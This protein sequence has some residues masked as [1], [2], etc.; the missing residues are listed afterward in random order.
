MKRLF[1]IFLFVPCFLNL[2][3]Q[4]T[5]QSLA[6]QFA[7]PKDEYK[8][9]VW[10]HWLGSNFSKEGI[11][12]DLEAM[13]KAGINGVVIFN[14][15]SWLDTA[16]NL[17]PRQT[18]R[19]EE[20]WDAFRHTLS[21]ARRLKITVGLHNSPGWST[22]G[23]P[24]IDPVKDGMKAVRVIKNSE[25]KTDLEFFPTYQL[26]HPTPEDV[27]KTAFEADK[28]SPE[29][30][31]KHWKNVLQPLTE[32]FGEFI[33]TTFTNIWIDSYEAWGQNLTPDFRKEFI[34]MKGYDPA[35]QLIAA[36]ERGDSILNYAT[37][38]LEDEKE[39][40]SEQTKIFL[41]DY[42]DVVNRLFLNCFQ[43][44]KEMVNDAGFQLYWEPYGSI[45]DAPF[46][47]EE[48][49][50]IADVPAT[51]FWVHSREIAGEERFAPAA[52]R[53]GKRI[54]AAEAFTG[55][56]ATCTFNE[57]PA[58]LKRPADM[59]FNYGVNQLFLHSWAHNPLSDAFQPG[60]SFAHYGTHFG[61][62]QTWTEE[63]RAFFTYLARCQMML[64]QGS[65]I[66][67]NDSVL[68]RSTPEAEIFFVRNTRKQKMQHIIDAQNCRYCQIWDPYSGK[69]YLPNEYDKNGNVKLSLE[70]DESIFVIFPAYKTHYDTAEPVNSTF[71][72]KEQKILDKWRVT[73]IPKTGEK[74]FSTTFYK[75]T[76]WSK[77]K[78][79]RIKYFSG[80]AVYE[81]TFVIANENRNPLVI[82]DLGE[83][84]D[85][86]TVEINDE[87]VAVLWHPPFTVDITDFVKRGTNS[88]KIKVTNTWQNRLIGD[89]QFPADYERI[90][91]ENNGLPAAK[92][93]PEWV[94][95]PSVGESKGV[96]RPSKERKTFVPWTYFD[97]N[98]ELAPA[99]LLGKVKLIIQT[100]E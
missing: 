29:A 94:K 10:W 79:S 14:A 35:P 15:P 42:H 67:R 80:S 72:Q 64:Q 21:E 68:H 34:A 8:P 2:F 26:T 55:M 11:T 37:N 66:E 61:R 38:G 32:R 18:F 69:I 36:Y 30:T 58:L 46:R 6:E 63:S 33:G 92:G 27:E 65:F 45:I 12:A 100:P 87:E 25:G 93:L 62:N 98:S 73:F 77:N 4:E 17:A 28:M 51:E 31:R 43:I 7:S 78:D 99:G 96:E 83:V 44:G 24:W 90:I 60:W 97:K 20:Y 86:A 40:F 59:A 70:K 16:Q 89:E 82:L 76:D 53:Y 3:S 75:L 74:P 84:H 49:I 1:C 56:E 39:S 23:G 88:L 22:T 95:V 13:K 9:Q 54:V 19:S 48:G 57:T 81:N 41:A 85:M 52:A 71:H 91:R 50:G 5:L 47:M